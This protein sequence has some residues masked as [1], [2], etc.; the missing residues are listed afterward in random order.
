[1]ILFQNSYSSVPRVATAHSKI[2]AWL[3]TSQAK[4]HIIPQLYHFNSLGL[5]TFLFFLEQTSIA[6]AATAKALTLANPLLYQAAVQVTFL[7]FR[8]ILATMA[9]S[10]HVP[11]VC[12]QTYALQVLAATLY[13]N[14][15]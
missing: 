8:S 5:L 1:M 15:S 3:L 12:L 14:F 4:V 6:K 9:T 11:E 13:F 7:R 2:N 10:D